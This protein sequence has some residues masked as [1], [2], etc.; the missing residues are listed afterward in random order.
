MPHKYLPIPQKK[1][2]VNLFRQISR[3]TLNISYMHIE[4]F[5]FLSFLVNILNQK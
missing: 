5:F 3:D 1:K 2:L 4:D